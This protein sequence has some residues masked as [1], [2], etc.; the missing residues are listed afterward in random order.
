MASVPE[1]P[2]PP[3]LVPITE[4]T[5]GTSLMRI[6]ND[7]GR[8]T[9]PVVG[10]WGMDARHHYS[11]SQPWNAD[12]SLIVIENRSG[13]SP[14]LLFLDGSTYRPRFGP[15]PGYPVWDFRW[16]PSTRHRNEQINVIR[17]GTE[18]MW[19]DVVACTKTRSWTLPFAVGGIGWGEGNPSD[20][21]RFVALSDQNRMFVVDMDPQPPHAPYPHKRI[22]P[23]YTFPPCSLG[24]D[25][26]DR[27]I[28]N[29]SISPS[30]LYIDV[31]YSGKSASTRDLHR[32]YEVDP[33]T[34]AIK[35][36][37]MNTGSLRCGAFANRPNGWIVPLKHADMAIDPFDGNEDVIIGGRSCPGSSIGRVVMVRLRDGRVTALTDPKGEA[38]VQHVSTRN[39]KRRGWVYVGYFKAAGKRFSDE[40]VAVKM[41]GSHA[42]ER[43]A[44]K[45]SASSGCYRCESHAVPSPDG[46][47]VIFASNWAADCGAGCAPAQDIKDYVVSRS[48]RPR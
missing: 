11:R 1:I 21:G 12:Q 5:F 37:N 25:P 34:L 30:G 17:A 15:C 35:P 20:D 43:L 46:E 19:Y 14:T 10:K 27:R 48:Q 2:R 7:A 13:G 45:H 29:L 36:H 16:H 23:T 9:G 3:Y 8:S 18:L 26:A 31:K 33:V 32:I 24:S 42:V 28:G 22:G 41:D 47:R 39:L 4:P 38:P 44:H 40:I 6:A